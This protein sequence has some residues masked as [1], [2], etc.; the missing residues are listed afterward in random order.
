[1]YH[2][3]VKLIKKEIY[4]LMSFLAINSKLQSSEPRDKNKQKTTKK[5][6]TQP[7]S[8]SK[9]NVLIVK[10]HA[11]FKHVIIHTICNCIVL[12][13]KVFPDTLHCPVFCY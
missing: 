3:S 7:I 1:M 12:L 13:L 9:N 2:Q 10:L 8:T 6:A 5:D 11:V 4:S